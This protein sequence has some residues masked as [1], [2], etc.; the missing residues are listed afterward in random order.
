M[1]SFETEKCSRC[2]GSGQHSFNGEHSRCYK[3]DGKNNG[4]ALTKRGHAAKAYYLAKFQINIDQVKEGD[5]VSKDGYKIRVT[6]IVPFTRKVKINGVS[7]EISV[8]RLQGKNMGLELTPTSTVRR[9]PKDEENVAAIADAL[10]YQ[11]TLTKTGSP[12]K[13]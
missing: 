4:L 1:T 7:S 10:E 11:S 6:E 5:L 2:G 13:R 8:V 12:R 9:F 3:C